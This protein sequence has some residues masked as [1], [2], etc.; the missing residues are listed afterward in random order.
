M[1]VLAEVFHDEALNFLKANSCKDAQVPL[2]NPRNS[3]FVGYLIGIGMLYITKETTK[4]T[5][6]ADM[7]ES[8]KILIR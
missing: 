5:F 6:V 3:L 2:E 4:E 1:Y 7:T 8:A